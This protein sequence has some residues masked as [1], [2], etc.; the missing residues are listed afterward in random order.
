MEWGELAVLYRQKQSEALAVT[1]RARAIKSTRADRA[2]K[3]SVGRWLLCFRRG[4]RHDR[5]RAGATAG[6]T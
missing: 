4:P 1:L 6:D 3:P 2:K 5:A